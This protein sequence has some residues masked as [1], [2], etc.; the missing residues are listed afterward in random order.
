LRFL[1]EK[2][3]ERVG[4]TRTRRADVRVVAATNRDLE[5]DVKAGRFREDLYFRLNVIEITLPPLWER[6]EDILPL[7]RRFLDF[8]ARSSGQ[9]PKVLSRAAEDALLAYPWPGN[10][11]ELRNTIERATI[12]WPAPTLEPAALSERI[13]SR[14]RGGPWLGGDFSLEAIEREHIQRVVSRAPTLEEAARLL[15]IESSTL[16]RKRKRYEG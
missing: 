15:G 1:Q 11:R 3:F 7:A 8:F 10:I 12:L 13:T 16:W 5:A 2:E 6:H 4:E 9:P 14:L